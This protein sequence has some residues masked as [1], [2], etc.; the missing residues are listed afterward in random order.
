M[1][2][3]I[4]VFAFCLGFAGSGLC[5]ADEAPAKEKEVYRASIAADGVQHVKIEGGS[6]F[7]KPNR[8]IVKLNV[9][10]ELTLSVE[11][12]L[13]PHTFVIKAPEAGIA[14]DEELSSTAKS[15][16]FTPTAAGKF[17]FYCR[18]KLLFL[19]SHR[20]KGMEGVLDVV[21]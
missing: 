7:F 15:V 12:S 20:D 8:V 9:P 1:K 19:E 10:V 21:E 11:K 6:H 17:P 18:N 2:A 4:T 16:R 14:I 3:A 5:R 13:V